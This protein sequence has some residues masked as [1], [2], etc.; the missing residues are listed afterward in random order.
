MQLQLKVHV[1][2]VDLIQPEST[3]SSQREEFVTGI[4]IE[5]DG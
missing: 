2:S 4:V 1:Y 3:I 5:I